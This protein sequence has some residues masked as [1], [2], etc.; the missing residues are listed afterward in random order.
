[1][2]MDG[3]ERE[4][5]VEGNVTETGGGLLGAF[6]C[7]AFDK[8]DNL[9]EFVNRHLLLLYTRGLGCLVRIVEVIS[10]EAREGLFAEILLL[11]DG[12]VAV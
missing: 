8:V 12:I 5:G 10:D 6:A 1:M 9:A 4:D 3:G 2:K 7:F 11:G